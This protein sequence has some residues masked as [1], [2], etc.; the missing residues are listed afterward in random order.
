[1]KPPVIDVPVI[2]N[3]TMLTGRVII[4]TIRRDQT[5]VIKVFPQD[6]AKMFL[7][8]ITN[9]TIRL[10]LDTMN[11]ETVNFTIYGLNF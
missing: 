11:N 2:D 4:E 1:M 6:Y 3:R 8:N 9:Q 10:S 7:R 5:A